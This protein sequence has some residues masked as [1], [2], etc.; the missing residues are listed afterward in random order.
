MFDASDAHSHAAC[1]LSQHR[2]LY[3]HA[4]FYHSLFTHS[5]VY[6]ANSL[7]KAITCSAL[8]TEITYSLSSSQVAEAQQESAIL[9]EMMRSS[10]LRHT[11]VIDA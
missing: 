5:H 6:F 11:E 4:R 1:P 9:A 3:P 2:H 7:I 8:A 10:G